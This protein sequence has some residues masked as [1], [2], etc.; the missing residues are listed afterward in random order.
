[1][2]DGAGDGLTVA[3]VNA[4]RKWGGVRT[5]TLDFGTALGERGNR[6][7]AIVRAGTSF[8]EACRQARFR[9]HPLSFGPKYNP[10]AIAR[11]VRIFA[12]EKPDVVVVNIS[13]DVEVGAVA[14]RLC[15][16]PVVHRVGL[17]EDYRGTP[18]ERVRHRLL[19]DRVLVPSDYLRQGLLTRF[20]W[21][22]P[23]EVEAIPNSKRME[24]FACRE[25]PDRAEVVVGVTSQLSPSKGHTYLLRAVA[26]LA[27]EGVRLRVRVAGTGA[28]EPALRDEAARLGL[29]D[30]IDF[31][32][33]QRDIPTFLAGLD[34][35]VLPS[36][37]ESFSNAV[38]EAMSSGLPVIAFEAGGVPEVVGGA[39]ILTPPRDVPALAAALRRI[40]TDPDLRRSLGSAARARAAEHYDLGRN[41]VRL[42]EFLR[43]VSGRRGRDG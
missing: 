16:I 32:G 10:L 43:R 12:R 14:A 5:W 20:P 3:F 33:F 21:L 9:V 35:Y 42:E 18:G 13:K 19:I 37:N 30:V 1:M 29:A 11:A 28:L 22:Q 6:V 39:G 24:R 8:E 15:R 26:K 40:A 2:R 31:C 17:L 23:E 4:N 38:L 25:R 41:A 34:A 7:V 27:E 36:L